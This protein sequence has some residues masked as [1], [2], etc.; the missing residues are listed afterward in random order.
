MPDQG[1]ALMKA[2]PSTPTLLCIPEPSLGGWKARRRLKLEARLSFVLYW[3]GL[4]VSGNVT[5][6]TAASGLKSMGLS[7]HR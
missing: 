7:C 2:Q 1:G 4:L 3:T 5:V 6:L